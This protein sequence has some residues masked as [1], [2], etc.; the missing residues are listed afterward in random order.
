MP[1]SGDQ[2]GQVS[3]PELDVRRI[4]SLPSAFIVQ[5]AQVG[6]PER[7]H[8]ENAIMVPA[9]FQSGMPSL[10]R[11]ESVSLVVPAPPACTTQMS[12]WCPEERPK[13]MSPSPPGNAA[14]AAG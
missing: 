7:A 4:G 10:R 8:L 2:A 3:W 5:I 11:A 12:I 14:S 6:N 9:A 1:P 13:A